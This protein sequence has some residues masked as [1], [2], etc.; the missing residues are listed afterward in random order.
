VADGDVVRVSG[1]VK[2]RPIAQGKVVTPD[3]GVVE[4][5]GAEGVLELPVVLA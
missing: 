4:G 5:I 2:A 3:G 1:E